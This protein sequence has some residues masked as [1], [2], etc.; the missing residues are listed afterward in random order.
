MIYTITRMRHPADDDQQAAAIEMLHQYGKVSRER[1]FLIVKES[2]TAHKRS[3][4]VNI[5]VNIP[6]GITFGCMRE[7][8]LY[9][10]FVKGSFFTGPITITIT[11][12]KILD[13]VKLDDARETLKNYAELEDSHA[14]FIV[15][16]V[17]NGNSMAVKVRH[18]ISVGAIKKIREHFEML[19]HKGSP[20]NLTVHGT[21]KDHS[22][23]AAQQKPTMNLKLWTV[24]YH[25]GV[26]TTEPRTALILA[27]TSEVAVA[28][29]SRNIKIKEMVKVI[30]VEGPFVNGHILTNWMIG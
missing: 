17:S 29:I 13:G 26:P 1:S 2:L 11:L 25:V 20:G 27:E 9:F 10:D 30:E 21:A 4:P 6:D 3:E 18:G 19:D 24:E 14:I 23:R 8:E 15:R 5:E 28:A 16:A 22:G 7:L 12:K